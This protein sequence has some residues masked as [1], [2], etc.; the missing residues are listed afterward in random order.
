MTLLEAA[1][2]LDRTDT[3]T[4]KGEMLFMAHHDSIRSGIIANGNYDT[5]TAASFAPRRPLG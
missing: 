1:S 4:Q 3:V 5:C 2:V